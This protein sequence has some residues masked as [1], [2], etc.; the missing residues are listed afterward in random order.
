MMFRVT[1]IVSAK[2]QR[3]SKLSPFGR[4]IQKPNISFI[5]IMFQ[6]ATIDRTPVVSLAWPIG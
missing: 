3:P 1:V 6:T 4:D 2:L 5:K